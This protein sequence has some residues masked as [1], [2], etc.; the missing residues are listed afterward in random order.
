MTARL[1]I[2]RSTSSD[3]GINASRNWYV[4][5]TSR[6]YENVS[7]SRTSVDALEALGEE[8]QESLVVLGDGSMRTSKRPAVTTT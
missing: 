5:F 1:P 6:R 8:T 2:V 7:V 4:C 3:D